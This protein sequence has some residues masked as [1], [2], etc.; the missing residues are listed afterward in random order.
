MTTWAIFGGSFDPPHVGHVLAAAW[1][2]STQRV[3]RVI[4]VPV[5]E[6]AFGKGVVP[7]P[8]RRRMT[9]LAFA[10]IRGVRVSDLEARMAGPSY[11]VKTLERLRRDHPDVSLRLVVGSDLVD[12]VPRWKE[13]ERIPGLAP[14]LVV[15]RGGHGE[16]DEDV[17]MPAVSSTE[18]RRRLAAGES[19]DA[20]VPRAVAA[21]AARHRLYRA[22]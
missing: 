19:V 1:V 17:L 6:H 10:P 20:L 18:V 16:G 8:H 3:D 9:E 5:R 22:R 21:Y 4:V 7:F 14:L 2:R 13:G 11:T 12:Q 15:G